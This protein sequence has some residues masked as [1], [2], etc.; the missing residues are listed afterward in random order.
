M[1]KAILAVSTFSTPLTPSWCTSWS[2][3]A[4]KVF[5]ISTN[6]IRWVMSC[7]RHQVLTSCYG[8]PT[9]RRAHLINWINQTEEEKR[10]FDRL[11]TGTLLTISIAARKSWNSKW[12]IPA[13]E[14]SLAC[15]CCFKTQEYLHLHCH[16]SYV[17]LSSWISIPC[18]PTILHVWIIRIKCAKLSSKKAASQF[19]NWSRIA[20]IL[21]LS[22]EL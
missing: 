20:V 10:S 17:K 9:T 14:N 7:S 22:T 15:Y 1:R 3:K 21:I 12:S 6:L 16:V 4:A 19:T 18:C 5:W 8:N 11:L 2:R 13:K